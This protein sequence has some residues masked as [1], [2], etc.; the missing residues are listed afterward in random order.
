M[1]SLRAIVLVAVLALAGV[2][3]L[4]SPAS[5][6]ALLE[7]SYPAAGASLP[8]A[9]HTMLLFFTE[10]PDPGLSPVSLLDSSGR[11]VAGVGKPTPAPGN[12]RELR[13]TLPRLADGV[14]TVNWRTVSKVDGHVTG[15]S[16]AFGIGV[17]APSGAAAAQA[18]KGGSPGSIPSP[19]AAAGLWLLY[20]GLALLAAAGVT[21]PLVFRWRLPAGARLVLVAGWLSAAVGIL[22]MT[23][24]EQAAAG[25]PFTELFGAAAG[26]SLLAQAAAVAICGLAAFDAARRPE[27]TRL[28]VLAAAAAGAL[29]VHALAGH[30]DT[31]SSARLLNVTDQW[32]HMLAAGV[33]VGGLVWLL[34]GL[35]GLDGA[36]RASAVR[37]F[38]Q[39]AFAAVAVIAVTG[40]LRAVPEVGSLGALVSTSFGVVLLI[41]TGLFM[42][43]MG[44]AWRN[45]YRLVPIVTRPAP[46][47]PDAPSPVMAGASADPPGRGEAGTG[48]R[49]TE[50]D[51]HPPE[52]AGTRAVRSLRRS[53]RSEVAVA[54]IVLAAAA[55]LSGLPP[56][57]FVEA[58]AGQ[59][60]TS[61]S[62]T[63]TGS[64]FATTARVRLT[65]SPGTAGPNRFQV[66]VLR[67]DTRRPLPAR[68]VRLEFSLPSNPDVASSLNLARGPGGTWNGQGTNLSIDGQ[69]AIDV[70]IQQAA[71]A[72]DVPLRLRTRLP[73]EHITAASQ[74]G[75]PTLYT[76]QLAEGRSLQA[77]LE[78]PA[79]G[80]GVA[81]FTFFQAS[82]KEQPITSASATAITPAGADQP[83]ELIRLSS[84]HFA[85]NLRLTPGRW[86]FRIAAVPAG[87]QPQSGY[88]SQTV[89]P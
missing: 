69:W 70:V 10:A 78:Q 35:R 89:R 50:A 14:Y 32:L 33:W 8:R 54:A 27:A 87:G 81:H 75:A 49:L 88:F 64:D 58:A 2:G 26:R 43:L 30:A 18:A 82:G 46:A 17:Q 83:L 34:L 22:I 39:L 51:A 40:V 21:G 9:P 38:S 77:Y 48:S 12:A 66:Q 1:R 55:V 59:K 63:V 62:I 6:H 53:V 23:L 5:A 3:V 85:A 44:V 37:R 52:G 42:A 36:A 47:A 60:T 11:T 25:V 28:I 24:A 57:A 68:A 84:G 73:P 20:W 56:S 31:Q 80:R 74:P 67:Y 71:S 76:I 45:R 19:A 72:V 4:A 86:T 41:K 16:F 61:P 15:G 29:Y 13:A 65:A 79:P 7:R